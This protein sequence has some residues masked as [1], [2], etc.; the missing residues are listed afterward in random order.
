MTI[1][2]T[3]IL[4]LFACQTRYDFTGLGPY[5]ICFLFGLLIIGL[6]NMFLINSILVTIQAGLGALVFS[7]Y[8]I[9]DTQ[10]IVGG[11]N[12][13]YSFD[14]DDYVLA[15]ISLYLDIINLFIYILQLCMGT[16]N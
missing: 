12:R 7:F 14:V 4:T 3:T 5:L 8:I 11:K 16:D 6:I 9:Y 2:I 13:Q 15:V 1:G 10:L